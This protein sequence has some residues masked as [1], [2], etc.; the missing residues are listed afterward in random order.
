M[1]YNYNDFNLMICTMY[2]VT[3]NIQTIGF[4]NDSLEHLVE[5][6]KEKQTDYT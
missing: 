2:S 5:N 4:F 6:M 3:L 1:N